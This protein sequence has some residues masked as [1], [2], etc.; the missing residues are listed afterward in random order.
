MFQ[1]K[2]PILSAT[3]DI[4]RVQIRKVR[5]Q[6]ALCFSLQTVLYSSCNTVPNVEVDCDLCLVVDLLLRQTANCNIHWNYCDE[7][8]ELS[9]IIKTH[10][11]VRLLIADSRSKS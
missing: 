1:L 9:H 10:I 4:Q 11:Q 6:F 3:P 5:E 7:C 8:L 2:L